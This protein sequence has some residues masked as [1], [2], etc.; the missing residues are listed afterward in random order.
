[1]QL[2]HYVLQQHRVVVHLEVPPD[3]VAP[4]LQQG[5]LPVFG[6][7]FNASERQ[8]PGGWRPDWAE[9]GLWGWSAG[10]H[11]LGLWT[12]WAAVRELRESGEWGV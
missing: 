11:V 5:A 9:R 8:R 1:M 10:G 7:A 12:L 6:R 3:Q 4:V 2:E